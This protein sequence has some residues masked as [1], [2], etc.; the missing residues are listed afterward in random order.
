MSPLAL[1]LARRNCLAAGAE[2][3]SPQ[4]SPWPSPSSSCV[5]VW[6]LRATLVARRTAARRRPRSRRPAS[7]PAAAAPADADTAG[8]IDDR[9][10]P[11]VVRLHRL[12]RPARAD[13]RRRRL[14]QDRQGG[15]RRACSTQVGHDHLDRVLGAAARDEQHD[16]RAARRC[17][18]CRRSRS[19][20]S[21]VNLS[22]I[23]AFV[24]DDLRRQHPSARSRSRSSRHAARI[25]R[26]DA[27]CAWCSRTCSATPGEYTG[28]SRAGADRVGAPCRRDDHLHRARQ[29]RRLRHALRRPPVRRLP[30]PA[31][32]ERV[33]GTGIG[34]ASV[35]RIVRRHGGE[36][37][38]EVEPERGARF[39]F[40]AARPRA[41]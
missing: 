40:A 16:R 37:W 39:H 21:P 32:R 5:A 30:A 8:A 11:R 26:P 17:R 22:Q 9:G 29:R 36:I 10:R 19:R 35:R 15:L 34:L 25:G 33:P 3:R 41:A 12:A 4:R 23:A 38:A 27:C 18:G 7:D 1:R 14:H 31:Q 20:A 13:P 6:R 28:N 24:V 2:P